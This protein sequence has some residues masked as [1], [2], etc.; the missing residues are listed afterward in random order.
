MNRIG[1][2]VYIASLLSIPFLTFAQNNKDEKPKDN[3]Q[4]LDLK[5]DGV[6][7]ISTEKAYKELLKGKNSSPVIVSIIDGGI[8]EEHEDLKKIMWVN[9]KEIP[10][11][12]IDDDKNGYID[13]INV[14]E[15]YF[16]VAYDKAIFESYKDYDFFWDFT[17]IRAD[18][19][20]LQTEM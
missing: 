15:N 11:N 7:G 17:A 18:V 20:E 9:S 1:K 4:N 6:F 5:S 12:G 8:D 2:L 3:W 19:P 10:G 16:V 14:P 13:D